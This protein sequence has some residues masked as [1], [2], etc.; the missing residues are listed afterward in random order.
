MTAEQFRSKF[1]TS[2]EAADES[3]ENRSDYFGDNVKTINGTR[4]QT[5][6]KTTP[7]PRMVQQC[8][9]RLNY[10]KPRD[11]MTDQEKVAADAALTDNKPQVFALKEAQRKDESNRG[12]RYKFE[13]EGGQIK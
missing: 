9:S 11:Q 5:G 13:Q 10:Q 4:Q 7:A 6:V 12:W 8:P 3:A 1:T 2:Q